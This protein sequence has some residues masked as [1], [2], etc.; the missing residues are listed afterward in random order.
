MCTTS[1]TV[2][3]VLIAVPLENGREINEL[4]CTATS[5]ALTWTD[6]TTFKNGCGVG[7]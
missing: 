5:S 1:I 4:K 2:N 3:G 7:K 6:K